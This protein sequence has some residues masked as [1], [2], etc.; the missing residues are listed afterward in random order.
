MGSVFDVNQTQITNTS[1]LGCLSLSLSYTLHKLSMISQHLQSACLTLRTNLFWDSALQNNKNSLKK[2]ME[3]KRK[4]TRPEFLV[5]FTA[6]PTQLLLIQKGA[7]EWPMPNP[8]KSSK[9]AQILQAFCIDI[10]GNKKTSR[11]KREAAFKG[12]SGEN[13]QM[14][15]CKFC[16]E[17]PLRGKL[18]VEILKFYLPSHRGDSKGS[19]LLC[20]VH[21]DAG[22]GQ[23]QKRQ[24]KTLS[25]FIGN[26]IVAVKVSPQEIKPLAAEMQYV[27]INMRPT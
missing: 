27:L 4:G 17:V 14:L 23:R 16:Q 20:K 1:L 13:W 8:V 18:A 22:G 7:Q 9:H 15:A 5:S 26:L 24:K 3:K 19:D 25:T 10:Q 21:L 11:G 12:Q 2:Q 6:G